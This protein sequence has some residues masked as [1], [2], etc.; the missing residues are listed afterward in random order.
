MRGRFAGVITSG[1][2]SIMSVVLFF[3]P[4]LNLAGCGKIRRLRG[5]W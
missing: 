2:L 1:I 4:G 3:Y 5:I